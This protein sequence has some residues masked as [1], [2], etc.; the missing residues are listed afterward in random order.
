MVYQCLGPVLC[1]ELL[2][3][4]GWRPAELG[5]ECWSDLN[6]MH[7]A[8]LTESYLYCRFP[9]RFLCEMLGDRIWRCIVLSASLLFSLTIVAEVFSY[10]ASS[11]SLR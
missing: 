2:C 1:V 11:V 5:S 10:Q 3:Y 9:E 4:V 8:S 6:Q 7:Q